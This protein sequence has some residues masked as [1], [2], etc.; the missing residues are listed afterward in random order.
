M[1]ALR[2]LT[3]GGSRWI[4]IAVLLSAITALGAC[5]DQSNPS[6]SSARTVDE[7][8]KVSRLTSTARKQSESDPPRLALVDGFD[9]GTYQAF[10][11]ALRTVAGTATAPSELRTPGA[12]RST[13]FQ[14]VPRETAESFERRA[15]SSFGR[16]WPLILAIQHSAD[17]Q[18]P[19]A[20]KTAWTQTWIGSGD[21]KSLRLALA[22]FVS[23]T[24]TDAKTRQSRDVVV[25]RKFAITYRG[26]TSGAATN[27]SLSWLVDT[28]GLDRC[29]LAADARIKVAGA[30]VRARDATRLA[31]DVEDIPEMPGAYKPDAASV[32]RFVGSC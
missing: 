21:Q 7:L 11:A 30:K 1:R 9:K 19:R 26:S 32:R 14:A 28:Y 5:G 20:I 31:D 15:I 23:T 8:S 29:T 3:S 22:T 25:L 24:V 17:E 16:Q 6:R 27:P 13:L 10:T 12:V 2:R 4:A 18:V